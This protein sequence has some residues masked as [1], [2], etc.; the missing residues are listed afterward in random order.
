MELVGADVTG[1]CKGYFAKTT[2]AIRADPSFD[3]GALVYLVDTDGQYIG[4]FP[5]GTPAERI[6]EVLRPKLAAPTR[7]S[8]AHATSI[9]VIGANFP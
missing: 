5:P 8:V 2:P 9:E 3:H 6:V 4:F 7:M 1:T